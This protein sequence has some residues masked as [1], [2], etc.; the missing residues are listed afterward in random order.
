[1]SNMGERQ[2]Q[3]NGPDRAILFVDGSNWYHALREKG[4]RDTMDL[5]YA[6]ISKK[7]AGPRTW[8]ATRYYGVTL[9]QPSDPVLY[10]NN[11]R[12]LSLIESDDPRV[13]V[14]LGRVE[15]RPVDNPLA[16]ELDVF[17]RANGQ[18]LSRPTHAHLATLV[19]R[20]R[21]LPNWVE[22]GVDV[23]LAVDL[24]RLAQ[25]DTYDAAYLLSA[26]GDYVPAVRLV[27]GMGKKVYGASPNFCS[28][29]DNAC[30]SFIPL[31][32]SWFADCYR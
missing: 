22:K 24:Y 2:Q 20:Y 21:S 29:L 26:D 25:E 17:L 19:R 8:V 9:D 16:D 14:H 27:R 18:T 11:R 6:A 30:N 31:P 23:A 28:A 13:S 10:A 3:G 5:D 15:P 4:V 1:M 32:G 12:F 7:L